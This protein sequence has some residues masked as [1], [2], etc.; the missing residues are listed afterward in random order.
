MSATFWS[1]M[2][3]RDLGTCEALL[4][5]EPVDPELIDRDWLEYASEFDLVRLD[6]AAIDLLG[7]RAD[8][9]RLLE[10]TR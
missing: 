1:M 3:S 7:R 5:G 6:F 4:R 8:L 10:E 2:I 9:H